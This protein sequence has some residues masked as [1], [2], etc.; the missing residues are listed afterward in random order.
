MSVAGATAEAVHR[1]AAG[2]CE[3]C[4]MHE[5][6]QGATFHVEHVLP[7]ARGGT[8]TLGNLAWACPGCNLRKADRVEV[9][10]GAAGVLVRLFHPRNDR[11]SDHFRWEGY[12][13]VPLTEVGRVTVEALD[14]NH[15]RR[16]RIR[17]AEHLFSMF[18]P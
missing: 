14:L 8:S 7:R 9:A 1:L 5:A 12:V 13:V 17:K 18:P 6:L 11:W 10:Q 3:Y 16:L 4:G 2:R 15:P